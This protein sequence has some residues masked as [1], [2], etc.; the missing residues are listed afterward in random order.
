[1]KRPGRRTA[2]DVETFARPTLSADYDPAS[3]FANYQGEKTMAD[4]PNKELVPEDVEAIASISDGV[5]LF[6]VRLGD[7][8]ATYRAAHNELSENAPEDED[9]ALDWLATTLEQL[10][11]QLKGEL[12]ELVSP[13][14]EDEPA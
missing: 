9:K 6:A 12:F 5:G 7:I 1:M 8:A 11:E 14:D 3:A 13:D 2:P 4:K 10:V